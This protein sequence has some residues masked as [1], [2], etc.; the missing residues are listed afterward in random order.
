[1]NINES[2]I[3]PVSGLSF[4]WANLKIV[5]K[6]LRNS[7]IPQSADMKKISSKSV[8]N[9]LPRGWGVGIMIFISGATR[10]A[11]QYVNQR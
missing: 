4:I 6:N 1:M 3:W 9:F 2:W 11:G 10:L 5:S 7:A 8:A